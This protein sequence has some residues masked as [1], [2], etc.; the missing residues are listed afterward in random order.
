MKKLCIS[1][2]FIQIFLVSCA[3]T[4]KYDVKH[5]PL[6]DVRNKSITVIPL[7]WRNNGMYDYLSDDLTN[8][9][10]TG[11]QRIKNINFIDPSILTNIDTSDYYKFVDICLYAEIV[12]VTTHEGSSEDTFETNGKKKTYITRTA[13]VNVKYDY[14]RT[15]D[16][17]ILASSNKIVSY[18]TSFEN[19]KSYSSMADFATNIAIDAT[20]LK[21]RTFEQIAKNA[22]DSI[23]NV[24]PY[25]FIF[26]TTKEKKNIIELS[27]KY[28]N[29]K[30][31]E[32]LVRQKKY[33]EAL[34]SYKNIYEQTNNVIAG[35]NAVLLLQA[36]GQFT[37]ALKLSEEL[38]ENISKNRLGTPF[39]IDYE[40]AN[41]KMIINKGSL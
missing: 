5:Q 32:K 36:E 26:Y 2:L 17:T 29:Y 21:S 31:P 15:T 13:A 18:S 27:Y 41:I 9:L 34:S 24:I 16:G 38:K 23:K 19:N 10:I 37:E 35:Y 28:K 39:N 8:G 3:T 12:N 22:A 4:V 1:F 20:L 25:D 11:I 30:K 40:I 33:S 7:A 14:I 6:V